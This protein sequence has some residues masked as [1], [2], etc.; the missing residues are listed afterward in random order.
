MKFFG[1]I[2]VIAANRRLTVRENCHFLPYPS[3]GTKRKAGP[4][5]R[6]DV[7]ISR[8]TFA[9]AL[10]ASFLASG[11][12]HAADTYKPECFSP[13]SDNKKTIQYPAKK[14]PYKIALVNGYVGNDWRITAIQSAKAWGARPDNAKQLADFKV[15]SV[16]ND[17][18]AQIA[19]ID[20]YIAAG[21]DAIVINA[22]NPTAFDAVVK[23]AQRAGT[24]LVTFDNVLD[25]DKIVQINED[26]FELGRMKAQAVV[27][28]IKAA[29]GDVTGQV[30]EISGLPGNSVDRD[31]HEG[32]RSVLDKY[33]GLKVVQV[34]G[35]WDAGTAEKGTADAIATNGKFD[36]VMVQEGAIGALHAMQAAHHPIVPIGVDAGN[37]TRELAAKGKYPGVTA[38]QAPAMSA[39]ALEAAV[40][41]LQGN[42]LPQKVFLP[43]PHKNNVD[44][45]EGK[46]YFPNLPPNF[47][48]TT[49]YP[50]CF[51]VFTPQ[52][53]MG[54]NAANNG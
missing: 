11:L 32:M 15:I 41:L 10:S 5:N 52:E 34:V 19:A 50:Q 22:V 27:D 35:N 29:K 46:D 9:M 38:A 12:A 23:R 25:S 54:Q 49:G 13:A 31:N 2:G 28:G 1:K 48:T 36:G 16:G 14:G 18:A 8:K 6:E 53:L 7:M 39:L 44:L 43:I 47:Y 40:V 37:G 24:V 4:Q 33:K 42:A 21:Y 3:A 17:S 51:P 26:Q 45:V 20:N 30:L